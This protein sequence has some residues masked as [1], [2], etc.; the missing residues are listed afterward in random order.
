MLDELMLC[1]PQREQRRQP[2]QWVRILGSLVLLFLTSCGGDDASSPPSDVDAGKDVSTTQKCTPGQSIACVGPAGCAGGQACKADGSGYEP[3]NCGGSTGDGSS[4]N[5]GNGGSGGAGGS[6]G[7]GGASG[8]G[9]MGGVSIDGSGGSDGATV[10]A[11]DDGAPSCNPLSPP[12]Q[13]GCSAGQKC[14]WIVV[15]DTPER[16]G[17]IGC[18]P[19]GADAIGQPCTVG[20]AGATSGYDTCVA[21]AICLGATCQDICG[22]DGSPDA[23]CGTGRAC[24]RYSDLFA[25]APDDPVAGVCTATCDP[26]TQTMESDAG[27]TTCGVNKGCYLLVSLVDTIAVCANQPANPQNLTHNMPITGTAFANSCAPGFMP[28]VAVQGQTGSECGALC[29]PADVYQGTNDGM[30]GRPDYEG[31]NSTVVNFNNHPATCASEGGTS[32][33][34]AVPTTGESCQYY[35]TRESSGRITRFSNTLGWCFNFQSYTYDLDGAGDGMVTAPYPRC[36]NLTQGDV[37]EP[38]NGTSDAQYFGCV[39]LPTPDAAQSTSVIA[40]VRPSVKA[41]SPMLLDRL[42]SYRD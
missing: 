3:C 22:F 41:A 12:G 8:G 29:K 30:S 11:G 14:T 18:A 31:G 35:W 10:D 40:G 9:G 1:P 32:V 4:G 26:L 38:L 34:P 28:R 15:A 19:N 37:L 27:T 2:A 7:T 25:N 13:Q 39:A 5:A 16:L 21:G 36:I 24:T 23:A 33:A 6:G 42:R 20:A 17:K